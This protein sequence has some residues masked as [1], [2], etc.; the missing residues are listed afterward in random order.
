[1]SSRKSGIFAC[2]VTLT[3]TL[4]GVSIVGTAHGFAAAGYVLGS[5][6]FVIFA[7]FSALGLHLLAASARTVNKT[8]SSF[9]AVASEAAPRFTL[10]I[11]LA[12][13]VKCFGV[14]TSYLTVIG[15]VMPDVAEVILGPNHDDDSVFLRRH[16]WVTVGFVTVAP[17]AFARTLG[18]LKYTATLA[19]CFVFFLVGMVVAYAV[20]PSLDACDDAAA[21]MVAATRA[22]AAAAAASAAGNLRTAASAF[23]SSG[24][25]GGSGDGSFSGGGGYGSSDLGWPATAAASGAAVAAAGVDEECFMPGPAFGSP[26]AVV[27]VLSIFVFGFTCHQNI[28][29]IC[30]ELREPTPRRVDAVIGGAVSTALVTYVTLAVAAYASLGASVES[31]VL[32]SFPESGMLTAARVCV[33]LLVCCCYPLQAHPSRRC[34]LSAW[35]A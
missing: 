34:L 27:R 25:G 7:C 3:N 23:G 17:L 28:F 2:L 29:T 11:D 12:V 4:L 21:D 16:F 31:D 9:Y 35:D 13:A 22:A 15:D 18:A 14:A 1:A 30:D 5:I 19:I 6:F 8:P 32:A 24:G 20:I 33:A 26:L 10:L